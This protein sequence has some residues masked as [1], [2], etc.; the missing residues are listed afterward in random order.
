MTPSRNLLPL[1]A[2]AWNKERW[3]NEASELRDGRLAPGGRGLLD[4][5]LP[6]A[7][8]TWMTRLDER[9][10][11]F[12]RDHQVD[13]HIV[14][15]AAAFVDMALEAGVDL[16]DGQPFAIEDFEIRKPLIMSDPPAGLILELSYDPGQRTFTIQS[17]F[18]PSETWS[19]HVVGS[20][21]S[22]R[23]ESSFIG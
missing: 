13:T 4:I 15:P 10:M 12:L 6:R 18:E 14:F 5:R 3:W 9:H 19:V 22:E 21:R 11:S 23:V 2:Y 7:T 8:P 20:M 17:R 16:F 1:P